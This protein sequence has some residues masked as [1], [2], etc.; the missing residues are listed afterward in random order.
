MFVVLSLSSFDCYLMCPRG[1][2]LFMTNFPA[3]MMKKKFFLPVFL[4]LTV[5]FGVGFSHA[6]GLEVTYG[7]SAYDPSAITLTLHEDFT[8]EYQDLSD[9]EAEVRVQGSYTLK[10]NQVL[11]EA[12]DKEISFH[13][14]WKISEDGVVARSRKGLT[15]YTL[16]KQ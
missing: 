13:K 14:T 7:V 11:L 15:F 12:T 10:K 16:Q 1:K 5:V 2:Q 9:R 6:P 4:S 8:F 3:P